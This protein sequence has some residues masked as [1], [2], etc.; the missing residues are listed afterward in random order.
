MIYKIWQKFV[1]M[2]R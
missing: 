1:D 2:R